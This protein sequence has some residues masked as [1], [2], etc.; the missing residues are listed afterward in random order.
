MKKRKSIQ[1][2]YR[3]HKWT[4]LSPPSPDSRS[5]KNLKKKG[6]PNAHGKESFWP[7]SWSKPSKSQDGEVQPVFPE[8]DTNL[9]REETSLDSLQGQ[10]KQKARACSIPASQETFQ[11]EALG[12]ARE[13][14]WKA[15]SGTFPTLGFEDPR[16]ISWKPLPSQGSVGLTLNSQRSS[17]KNAKYLKKLKPQILWV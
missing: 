11:K 4:F 14:A 5:I 2:A 6:P 8:L 9:F 13:I 10:E 16:F 12:L 7:K 3:F 1:S 15:P 17:N